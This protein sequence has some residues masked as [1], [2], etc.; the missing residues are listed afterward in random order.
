TAVALNFDYSF[1]IR[2]SRQ[3]KHQWRVE[4]IR[5]EID[6][7]FVRQHTLIP[8]FTALIA[9]A[10]MLVAIWVQ[11]RQAEV[12][13]QLN[14][15][16]LVAQEDYDALVLQRRIVDR[17]HRRYEQFSELGFVGMESRLDWIEALRVSSIELTLPRVSYIIQPQLSAIS[18]VESLL[19]GDN[20]SVHVSKLELEMS[21]VH[22]L[23][24]L[25]F[26]DEL[27][28]SAPGLIKVDACN[29]DW[30]AQPEV[31]L[32]PGVNILANCTVQI[33]SVITSDVDREEAS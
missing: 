30:Q 26:I 33:F 27:Q 6:W 12:H 3:D 4:M 11:A 23:D 9:T 1:V 10:M 18:P 15:A 28:N 25:R 14:A 16:H 8:G 17:Y 2:S 20:I 32:T 21:L 31:Q 19:A 22:E 5:F 29:L 24:L 13:A 7:W